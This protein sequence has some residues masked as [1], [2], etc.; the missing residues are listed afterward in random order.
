MKCKDILS[1]YFERLE[2]KFDCELL[3]DGRLS[4]VTPYFYPDHDRI[5]VYLREKDGRIIISDLGETLRHL[6]AQGID[7][8]GSQNLKYAASKIAGG[9]NA[10][11]DNGII[12]KEG[13]QANAGK[14]M[15][16]VISACSAVSSMVYGNKSYEPI[17]FDD[18]VSD[19][20]VAQ[21]MSVHKSVKEFGQSQR[22]YQ[23]SMILRPPHAPTSEPVGDLKPIAIK[24]I[25]PKHGALARDVNAAF[26]MW[27]DISAM[28][29]YRNY[30]LFNDEIAQPSNSIR[31]LLSQKSKFFLWTKREEIL[32]EITEFA[33]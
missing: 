22:A 28:E 16:E 4:I 25:S 24:T 10:T 32:K 3:P 6:Y 14:T 5:E 1:D 9:F 18:E 15:H 29:K 2:E 23:L 7:V 8:L 17:R 12:R 31:K 33:A 21:G 26:T 20:F 11:L 30:T 19:Y 13:S 27:A